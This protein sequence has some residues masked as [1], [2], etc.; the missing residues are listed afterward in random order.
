MFVVKVRDQAFQSRA[1]LPG[2]FQS[3]RQDA[4]L[5]LVTA[6]A[7]DLVLAVSMTTG[8]I[9]GNSVIC[10]RRV[11]WGATPRR[12]VPHLAQVVTGASMTVSASPP[13]GVRLS[14]AG[15]RPTF[16]AAFP[17]GLV[18]F[19]IPRRWL[20]RVARRRWRFFQPLDLGVQL[21][22]DFCLLQHQFDQFF[23]RQ[24][25]TFSEWAYS[26]FQYRSASV[27]MMIHRIHPATVF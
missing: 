17:D 27:V 12:S 18:P 26:S 21:A 8:L 23:P 14:R 15:F 4:V 19:P 20:R 5:K 16:L 2:G 11:R 6:G 3:L 24:S 9:S 10:R 13:A 25:R 7:F 1:K 22:D